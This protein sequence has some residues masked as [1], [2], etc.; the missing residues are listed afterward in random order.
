[1]RIGV[2][3]TGNVGGTLGRRFAEAGH[4]VQFGARP[5]SPTPIGANMSLGTVSEAAAFGELVVFAVPWL[6]AADAVKAAGDLS[7]KIVFDCINPVRADF[8][9]LDLGPRESAG[10][11][12]A[13]LMPGARVVKIFNTVGYNVMQNPHFNGTPA[14]MLY[15]GDDAEAKS[16]AAQLAV[17]IGFDPVDAGPLSQ[18]HYLENFAWLWISM[19]AKYGHGREIAFRFMK[20]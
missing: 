14:S 11:K 17:D 4:E 18:S 9:G 2:I 1:M 10:E 12:F 16:V 7:G 15:C 8:S 19:A 6:A 13:A 3:G 5:G 20:R